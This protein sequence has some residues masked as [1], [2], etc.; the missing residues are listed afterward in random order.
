[1]KKVLRLVMLIIVILAIIS[2]VTSLLAINDV[3]WAV[4]LFKD[5]G[6]IATYLGIKSAW[7]LL[8]LAIAGLVLAAII[9]P[10]EFQAAI[11]KVSR[12]LSKAT[13]GVAKM[14]ASAAGGL[15]AGLGAGIFSSGNLLWWII[16]GAAV[17]M[18]WPSSEER[19]ARH[20]RRIEERRLAMEE[21]ELE[22][23]VSRQNS[24]PKISNE[25]G[26]IGG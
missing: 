21:R 20:A 1:M 14:A 26:V 16:G 10:K 11:E 6:L 3:S 25:V 15:L 18:L 5:G 24:N 12:G 2:I 23:R 9:M 19:S 4:D 8:A 7:M 13:G 17:Y 22:N